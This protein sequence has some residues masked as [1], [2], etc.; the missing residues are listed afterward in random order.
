MV[1]CTLEYVE[2]KP[3]IKCSYQKIKIHKKHK[4]ISRDDEY[5]KFLGR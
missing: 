2:D 4:D 1:L 5:A 3:D